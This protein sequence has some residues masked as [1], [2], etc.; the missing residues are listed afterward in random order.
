M[1]AFAACFHPEVYQFIVDGS[2]QTS[3]DTF[4]DLDVR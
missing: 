3:I 1:Y 2:R 4:P